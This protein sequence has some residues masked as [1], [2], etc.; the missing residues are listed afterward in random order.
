[1]FSERRRVSGVTV[2]WCGVSASITACYMI[3]CRYTLIC[4][5]LSFSV[6]YI[7]HLSFCHCHLHLSSAVVLYVHRR[8]AEKQFM[9]N[10][11]KSFI[12]AS[13]ALPCTPSAPPD[14][15]LSL[16]K[17]RRLQHLVNSMQ[18]RRTGTG[19]SDLL[20]RAQSFYPSCECTETNSGSHDTQYA[21]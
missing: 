6:I 1:M 8:Q 14:S 3:L 12:L 11:I 18:N 9:L 2:Q 7:C 5:F 15:A 20:K 21:Q 10:G 13:L 4:R 19:G 16:T 17:L